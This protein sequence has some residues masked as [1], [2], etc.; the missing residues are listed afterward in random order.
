MWRREFP[1]DDFRKNHRTHNRTICDEIVA[2]Y[3]FGKLRSRLHDDGNTLNLWPRN[4]GIFHAKHGPR[5][6][7]QS[8]GPSE[9]PCV[10]IYDHGTRH[11]GI[12]SLKVRG[13]NQ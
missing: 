5:P 11:Y 7:Y 13:V 8:L 10:Y 12:R 1:L 3:A 6:I 4:M 9:W 2:Y